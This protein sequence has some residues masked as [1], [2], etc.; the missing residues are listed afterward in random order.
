MY[1]NVYP[2]L[3][4]VL[5]FMGIGAEWKKSIVFLCLLIYYSFFTISEDGSVFSWGSGYGG[6]LG[7]GHLRD[8]FT[9]LRIA[10]L[11]GKDVMEIACNELHSVAVCSKYSF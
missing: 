1:G 4:L 3:D 8:R 5:L 11:H 7:Q 6:C 9:P 2:S 10:A